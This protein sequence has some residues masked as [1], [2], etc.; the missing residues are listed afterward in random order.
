[1]HRRLR[2]RSDRRGGAR[3]TVGFRLARLHGDCPV[4]GAA[5]TVSASGLGP[6]KIDSRANQGPTYPGRACGLTVRAAF[7]RIGRTPEAHRRHGDWVSPEASTLLQAEAA[8]AGAARGGPASAAPGPPGRYVFS[9]GVTSHGGRKDVGGSSS[10]A[11]SHGWGDDM[12]RRSA[13]CWKTVSTCSQRTAA[14]SCCRSAE[15]TYGAKTGRGD[16]VASGCCFFEVEAQ[17]RRR[18]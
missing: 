16:A 1:M 9:G 8:G 4:P 7:A 3:V 15:C 10:D 6:G 13:A 2:G 14:S 11:G 12:G 17:G 18:Q 5:I